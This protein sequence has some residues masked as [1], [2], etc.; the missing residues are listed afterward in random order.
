M[1]GLTFS[2]AIYEPANEKRNAET[3]SIH[4]CDK[5]QFLRSVM[6][7]RYDFAFSEW[8]VAV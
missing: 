3:T 7:G 4:L 8:I 6:T 2:Q 5:E 1:R